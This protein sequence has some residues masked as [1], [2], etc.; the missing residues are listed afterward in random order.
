MDRHMIM[1]HAMDVKSKNYS[2]FAINP[3]ILIYIRELEN[4]WGSLKP[5]NL[6]TEL[7]FYIFKCILLCTYGKVAAELA[8]RTGVFF[9]DEKRLISRM[10]EI[11]NPKMVN[12]ISFESLRGPITPRRV[13]GRVVFPI[14]PRKKSGTPFSCVPC[15]LMP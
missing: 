8:G 6:T 7:C 15:K 4:Y 5:R 2:T 10:R 1:S 9:G 13:N 11:Q 12:E 14:S 3:V